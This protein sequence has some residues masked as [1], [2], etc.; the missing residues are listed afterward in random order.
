VHCFKFGR[1]GGI[2]IA[3]IRAAAHCFKLGRGII[4]LSLAGLSALLHCAVQQHHL[5]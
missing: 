2:S 4:V 3:L 1:S 5:Q